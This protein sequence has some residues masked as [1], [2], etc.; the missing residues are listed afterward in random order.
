MSV[1][2][3]SSFLSKDL[4]AKFP[5][6]KKNTVRLF[7]GKGCPICQETGYLGRIG[8]FEIL[9]ISEPIKKL[10]MEKT[11]ASKIREQAIKLGMVT[12]FENGIEK[13][14]NAVTTIEEILK[15]VR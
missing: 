15:A 8:I 9:E 7:R 11:N 2:K 13:V 5:K 3:L 12:M 6:T 1:S 14:Q 4:I 10:V